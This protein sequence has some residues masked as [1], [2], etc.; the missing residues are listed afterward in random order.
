MSLGI[1]S[2]VVVEGPGVCRLVIKLYTAKLALRFMVET[3]GTV[4]VVIV[5]VIDLLPKVYR[6]LTELLFCFM[7]SIL[8]VRRWPNCRT[9]LMTEGVVFLFRISIG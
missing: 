5:W 2:L 9:V 1:V 7:T 4:D 8:V 6:L 3:I